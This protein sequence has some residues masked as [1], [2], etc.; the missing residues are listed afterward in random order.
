MI[1]FN[2]AICLPK[3]LEYA[4]KSLKRSKKAVVGKYTR[5]CTEWMEQRFDVRKVLLTTSCTAALEMSAIL[6]DIQPGDEVI[7]PS[8]TFVTTANA[9]V[10]RG[11]KA[12]FA[13]IRPDTMNLDENKLE[14]AITEKTKA[15]VV[16]HYAGVSCEM[17]KIMEVA[18]KYDIPVVEDAAQAVM[19][20][21]KNKA[22]GTIGTFGCYSFH[23]TKNYTM[24]EGGALLINDERYIER[25]EILREKGTNRARFFRGM[26][27][28]YSWVDIGSSYLPSEINAAVLYAQLEVADEINE[29][30]F[31]TWNAYYNGLKNQPVELPYIPPECVHN[32]HMFYVKVQNL[33]QRQSIIKY[34]RERGVGAV[35]HYVPLHSS[36]G[37][38]IYG[39]FCGEDRYTTKESN[40]LLRLPMWYGISLDER[41]KI[42]G[43]LIDAVARCEN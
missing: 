38:E 13:D 33:K 23:E 6:L 11:A 32:S 17:E 34:L 5:L 29:N 39:E 31:E 30:R 27:D 36:P 41:K 26:V 10:L 16:V 12:I 22:C 18:K 14:S 43:T 8:Y 37:G 7:M 35:F 24:G 1:P 3:A 25:A 4:T 19:S 42:I 15:I 9:F 21:Y 2:E 20:T 40:R 28:K